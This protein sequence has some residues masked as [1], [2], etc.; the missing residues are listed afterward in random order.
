MNFATPETKSESKVVELISIIT[1]Q[2]LNQQDVTPRVKFLAALVT[3]LLG[4]IYA[5]NEVTEDE[6][7]RLKNALSRFSSPN[8]IVRQLTMSMVQGVLK[9]KLF[10]KH[11]IIKSFTQSFP[12][13]KKLCLILLLQ[14]KQD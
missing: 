1:G 12:E 4:V 2:I 13:S 14:L 10:A 11:E 3:V 9:N 5:D 6:K 8:S 7:Q